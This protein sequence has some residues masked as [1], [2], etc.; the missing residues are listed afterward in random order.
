MAA[1]AGEMAMAAAADLVVAAVA[2]V[3]L[4]AQ[5]GQAIA[6]NSTPSREIGL[7]GVCALLVTLAAVNCRRRATQ[8]YTCACSTNATRS[9]YHEHA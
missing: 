4:E 8:L 7:A 5:I 2:M 3:H 6:A 9:P 1:T